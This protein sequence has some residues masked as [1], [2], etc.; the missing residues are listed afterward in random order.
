ME[1]G[2]NS[3]LEL[4]AFV[5]QNKYCLLSLIV[6]FCSILSISLCKEAQLPQHRPDQH[7]ELW[8]NHPNKGLFYTVSQIFI[9]DKTNYWVRSVLAG[10]LC[11]MSPCQ[12]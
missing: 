1:V 12:V 9:F 11:N 10:M 5:K 2:K 4:W 7:Q 6:S 3:L 8:K